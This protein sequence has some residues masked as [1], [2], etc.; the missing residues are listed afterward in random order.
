MTGSDALRA[1]CG[2]SLS[3]YAPQHR[4]PRAAVERWA[5]LSIS[6]DLYG[7]GGAVAV[8]EDKV[9]Q[10]LGMPAAV[11]MPTGT[12]AQQIALR[13]HAD[14]RSSRTVVFHPLC[15]VER[16]EDAPS[17]TCMVCAA[18]RSARCTGWS[19][20]RICRRSASRT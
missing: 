10:L 12:M 6:P 13:I 2:R 5:A 15:H 8:V 20:S 16:N 11:F 19:S 9:A 18:G 14:R 7:D 3:L 4:S 1:S 17:S